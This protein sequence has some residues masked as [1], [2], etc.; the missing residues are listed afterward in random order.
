MACSN[1]AKSD[2]EKLRQ[3]FESSSAYFTLDTPIYK[4]ID[5]KR[6]IKDPMLFMIQNLG[7]LIF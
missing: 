3:Y 4:V 2:S 5:K 1:E 7:N 6:R